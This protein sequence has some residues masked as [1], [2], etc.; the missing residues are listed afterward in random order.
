MHVLTVFLLC[1]VATLTIAKS[2]PGTRCRLVC[3]IY[4]PYSNVLDE[5]GCPIC[6][7]KTTPC[8]N[9]QAPLEDYSCGMSVDRRDCPSTHYCKVAP[10]DAYAVC[11]PRSQ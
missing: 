2:I 11:C 6:A 8:E 3:M 1:L 9:D 5:D 7:C 10:N 4:C